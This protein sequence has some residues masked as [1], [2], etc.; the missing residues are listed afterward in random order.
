[1]TAYDPNWRERL[2]L[3][4]IYPGRVTD[5]G[6]Y[7]RIEGLAEEWRRFHAGIIPNASQGARPSSPTQE[8]FP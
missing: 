5:C 2:I 6:T 3:E 1:M 7:Y 8:E 4:L